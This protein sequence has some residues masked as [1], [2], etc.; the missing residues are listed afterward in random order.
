ML[1]ADI[2]DAIDAIAADRVSGAASLVLRGIAILHRLSRD[3]IALPEAARGLCA[4]Q[5]SMA[6]FRTAAAIAVASDD[7]AASLDTLAERIRR[8]PDAIARA[9]V[10]V[11]RLRSPDRT[12]VRIVT[13]SRS[14]LVEHVLKA[15]V[16]VE[17]THVCCAES[18]PGLE[19]VGLAESLGAAG[20]EVEL[21]SDAAIGMAV[22]DADAVVVGADAVTGN[23]FINKAGTAGIAALGRA[24][25]CAVVVLAGREKIVPPEVFATLHDGAGERP[26]KD[27]AVSVRQPLFERIPTALVGQFATDAGIVGPDQVEAVG[28]WSATMRRKYLSVI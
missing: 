25:G 19:G 23:S 8:A 26:A 1:P 18:R 21:Y 20:A 7:S 10:P 11:L 16:A 27:G 6:G 2:R 12:S 4:A 15:L 28:I 3:R 9:I 24:Y 5:P 17:R 14:A 13:C 22:A